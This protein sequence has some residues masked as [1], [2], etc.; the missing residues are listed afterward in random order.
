[1]HETIVIQETDA[2]VMRALTVA[3][4]L[5]NFIICPIENCKSDYIDLIDQARP[6]LVMLDY[7]L[8]GDNCIDMCRAIKSR[9]PYLPVI[10]MSC[11]SNI[12]EHFDKAGFDAYIRKPFDLD[13]LYLIVH[14]YIN[15]SEKE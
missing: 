3:L 10:A 8:S 14:K 15:K 2:D 4:E 5:E 11:N 9:F 7:R 13:L 6:H 1:M 12:H